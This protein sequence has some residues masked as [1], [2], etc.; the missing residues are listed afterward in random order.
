MKSI[1]LVLWVATM[2]LVGCKSQ[3][4]K[5]CEAVID[6][7]NRMAMSQ[8]GHPAP[9]GSLPTIMKEMPQYAERREKGISDCVTM[10]MNHEMATCVLAATNQQDIVSCERFMP[11][12]SSD[13]PLSPVTDENPSRTDPTTTDSAPAVAP[14]DEPT[15]D[16]EVS[17][18][19]D[20]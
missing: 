3:L 17:N 12:V 2:G 19:G 9:T 5:D 20:N 13:A 10:R 18:A 11:A 15:P 16:E 6:H 1:L 8:H 7:M 14:S 4:K